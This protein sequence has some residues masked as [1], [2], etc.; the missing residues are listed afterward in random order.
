M[1]QVVEGE[2]K[3]LVEGALAVARDTVTVN[4][5]KHEGLSRELES[6]ERLDAPRLQAWLGSVEIPRSLRD[7]VLQGSLPRAIAR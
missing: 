3:R 1:A 4:G 5:K 2:V 6:V 7:F